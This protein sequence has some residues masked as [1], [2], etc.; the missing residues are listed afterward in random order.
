LSLSIAACKND[1]AVVSNPALFTGEGSPIP[2][3]I[4]AQSGDVYLDNKNLQ[5]WKLNGNNW[6]PIATLSGVSATGGVDST[7][8]DEIKASTADIG[9]LKTAVVSANASIANLST[10]LTTATEQISAVL[11]GLGLS[12]NNVT[13]SYGEV[14]AA[15]AL[16]NFST[17]VKRDGSG[18]IAVTEVTG[19]VTGNVT[20]DVTGNA[21]TATS[22]SSVLSQFLGG[23]G[24]SNGGYLSYG[25]N[26]ITLSTSGPTALALPSSGILG[27]VPSA[28]FVK[29]SGT[30][31]TSTSSLSLTSD[32]TGIL[33]VANGGTGVST[34]TGTGSLVLSDSPIFSGT[35]YAP[36]I[37]GSLNGAASLNI[38][39]T[40]DT[41]S[42]VLATTGQI[43]Y[44]YKANTANELSV[45]W[46][47]GQVQTVTI[48]DCT[49]PTISFTNMNSGG[50]YTLVVTVTAGSSGTIAFSAGAI[51]DSSFKA[52]P[53][54]ACVVNKTQLYTFVVAGS[55]VYITNSGVF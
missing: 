9:A 51:G 22:L 30:V 7:N 21:S 8:T 54:K 11:S 14:T 24:A 18:N 2:L 41:I 49:N 19:N 53:D 37:T 55:T 15:T 1:Q 45:D 25:A 10:G 6:S 42:G 44:G 12:S 43:N 16:N 4:N 13:N 40:G 27:A 23:T 33:P 32:V 17:L 47:N 50:T 46:S 31:L 52:V 5:M 3:N 38:L 20:G 39:K 28:G 35:V 26:N 29:S 36:S 34:K 48:S